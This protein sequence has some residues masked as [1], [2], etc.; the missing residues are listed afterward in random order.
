[1]MTGSQPDPRL[2]DAITHRFAGQAPDRL[3][4][5]IV[6]RTAVERQ[7]PG[8]HWS[9]LALTAAA[10]A[11]AMVVVLVSVAGLQIAPSQR[12]GAAS[13]GAIATAASRPSIPTDGSCETDAVCLGLLSPGQHASRA[14]SPGFTFTVPFGW[15]NRA[16]FGGIFDL[17]PVGRP[18]DLMGLYR[19]PDPFQAGRIAT[20]VA[21]TS[22]ALAAF[23]DG[24]TDLVVAVNRAAEIG[25]LRGRMLEV[26][27]RPGASYASPQCP[28]T[29]CVLLFHA[30]QDT[31][32]PSWFYYLTLP[33]GARARIYVLDAPDGIVLVV[34]QALD[35]QR[36][37]DAMAA[38]QP[39][40]E[41]I[42]FEP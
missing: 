2:H 37:A 6:R 22:E 27:V 40:V 1:M 26:S 10:L 20:G 14:F 18:G 9:P 38:A 39:I 41:S 17:R 25:G 8:W 24:D 30:V 16:A 32:I 15:M 36:F 13:A 21:P 12:G 23:L 4:E 35:G 11:T 34:A 33:D 31:V 7:R 5:R 28:G 42:R 3:L 29:R 19:N